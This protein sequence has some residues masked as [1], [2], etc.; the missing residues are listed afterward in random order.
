M[1]VSMAWLTRLGL[2]FDIVGAAVLAW[3]L[4]QPEK[5]AAA[6][7]LKA[8]AKQKAPTARMQILRE[9]RWARWGLGLLIIGFFLQLAGSLLSK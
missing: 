7:D 2:A 8:S 9:A 6:A 3:P 1:P 5:W 4:I